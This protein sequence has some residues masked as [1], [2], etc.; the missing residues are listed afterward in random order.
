MLWTLV[1]VFLLGVSLPILAGELSG[2]QTVT[3]EMPMCGE[4]Y[5]VYTSVLNYAFTD[6]LHMTLV[7]DIHPEWNVVTDL[8]TTVYVPIFDVI[9]ATLG[10]RQGVYNSDL[11]TVPYAQVTLQF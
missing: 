5:I 2:S 8:S 11:G 7:A 1:V 3:V 9:Y 4:R 6:W 10:V